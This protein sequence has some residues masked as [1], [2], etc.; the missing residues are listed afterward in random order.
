M[1]SLLP[2]AKQQFINPSTGLPLVGGLVYY[3]IPSTTTAK[4]TYQDQA[5]TIPNTNPITLDANGQCIAW[6]TG[7]YRQQVYD[8]LGNL[9]WDQ[10]TADVSQSTQTALPTNAIA[11]SQSALIISAA[12]PSAP[13]AI[14]SWYQVAIVAPA[15]S[16]AG[17]ELILTNAPSPWNTALPINFNGVAATGNEWAANDTLYLVW[18]PASSS[19]D[20]TTV[21][22][23][24]LLTQIQEQI[25]GGNPGSFSS[26][27]TTGNATIDGTLAVTG[28]ATLNGGLAVSGVTTVAPASTSDEPVVWQQSMVGAAYVDVTSSR[29]INTSGGSSTTYTYSGATRPK[30]VSV[31]CQVSG[32]V[33]DSVMAYVNGAE[34]DLAHADIA[35]SGVTTVSVTATLRF[36]VFPGQTYY[37]TQTST[38]WTL[39]KWSEVS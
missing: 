10:I 3:Y 36:W 7:A 35:G 24:S 17:A 25:A 8:S 20:L 14:S 28:A 27:A 6:G 31:T 30:Q 2:N 12:L 16:V 23:R 33:S 29:A 22:S 37:V 38:S 26:L 32:S 4:A 1:S 5:Q 11:A 15:N 19:W 39:L 9:I 13:S 18:N 21:G 34:A